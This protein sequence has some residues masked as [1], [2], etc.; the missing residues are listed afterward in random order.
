MLVFWIEKK[1]AARVNNLLI[2]KQ[3]N[4]CQHLIEALFNERIAKVNKKG[5][6]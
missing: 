6:A 4:I 1:R 2:Y 5:V 3:L